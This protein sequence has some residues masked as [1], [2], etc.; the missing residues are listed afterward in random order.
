MLRTKMLVF[1]HEARE[2][3]ESERVTGLDYQRC[4]GTH[5]ASS[6]LV[7][8]V[9]PSGYQTGSDI[10]ADVCTEHGTVGGRFVFDLK[11]PRNALS[12]H[13]FQMID[14]VKINE[15]EYILHIPTLVVSRRVVELLTRQ[16]LGRL[17]RVTTI[18]NQKFLP[19]LVT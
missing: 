12:E 7:G 5:G 3:F 2:L 18:L 17:L 16:K 19:I 11:T 13:D 15:R 1:T 6:P 10:V 9:V 8:T 14:R 4:E